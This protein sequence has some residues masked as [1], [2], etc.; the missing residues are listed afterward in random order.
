MAYTN[1]SYLICSTDGF[2]GNTSPGN[3]AP[4]VIDIWLAR[5]V[6]NIMFGMFEGV[7]QFTETLM[8]ELST[9]KF[10]NAARK[11]PTRNH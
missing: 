5:T 6:T 11:E 1:T 2:F 4:N 10:P 9:N 8:A 7:N 3:A